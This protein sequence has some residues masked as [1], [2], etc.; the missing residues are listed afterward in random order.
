MGSGAKTEDVLTAILKRLGTMDTK[1]KALDPLQEKVIALEESTD[2]MGTQAT[3]LIWC[4]RSSSR[5]SPT[6]RRHSAK[7]PATNHRPRT[8]AGRATTTMIRVV[9]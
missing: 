4:T 7:R 1:L 3:T 8:D 5:R 2:D 9:T 6:L